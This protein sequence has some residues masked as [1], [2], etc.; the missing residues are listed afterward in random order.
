MKEPLQPLIEELTWEKAKPLT[1]KGC[2]ILDEIIDEI[3]PEDELTF[4]SVR[5]PFGSLIIH[6]DVI[7]LPINQYHTVPITDKRIPKIW[8]E[9][10]GYRSIPTG[11]ITE[12]SVEIYREIDEKVFSVAVSAPNTGLELG[13]VEVFGTTAGYTVTSGARSLYM[14]PRISKTLS[15]KKLRKEFNVTCPPPKKLLDHW[16]VFRE[17]Y[18]SPVFQTKWECRTLFLTRKWAEHM[19]RDDKA[20]LK[21]KSYVQHKAW[22]H[23][24]LGRRKVM[25]DVVW[26]QASGLL[27]KQGIKPDPYVVDTLKHTIFISLG[28]ITGSRP[29]NGDDS[30]GP[31]DEIQTIYTDVYG[32]D[33]QI[34]TIMRPYSFS[35]QENKPV[36]YSMQTP[37]LLSSTPNFRSM[38]SNIEDMRELM[39]IKRY[40]FEQD[41]GNLKID[42]RRFND[43]IN[44]IKFDYFHGEMYA[45]GND[46]RP[47]KEIPRTDNEF[48]YMPKP[49]EKYKF[50]DNGAYI[51]GCIRISKK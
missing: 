40:V 24:E 41:Y 43:L 11:M 44:E 48:L 7:Y 42:N 26:Q 12:N 28:G 18:A 1:A 34:P 19:D 33:A 20:W 30:I 5:Y 21:L 4:V 38:S 14:I 16:H 9:K 37:M 13:I 27:T 15:H 2:K 8:R 10:L 47:T 45:Y 23:S 31:I 25:L 3:S 35:T 39:N 22:Q 17:L 46:I 36:Y 32:L 49:K 6:N 29:A 51:R 50:A